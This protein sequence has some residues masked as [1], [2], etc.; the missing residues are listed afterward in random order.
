LAI[1]KHKFSNLN[2]C[3]IEAQQFISALNRQFWLGA[4]M[5]CF[6]S[7]ILI[8]MNYL[9]IGLI[10]V[11]IIVGVVWSM[12]SIMTSSV[13]IH[14]KL[15]ALKEK[16]KMAKTKEELQTVWEELKDVN[17]ECWHRSFSSKVV[18]VKTIIETKYD[19]LS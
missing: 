17:K 19:M 16:A 15:N 3:V 9:I 1:T 4:V 5:C 14:E 7:Q 18:E 8:N 10:I 11:L 6:S 12:W 2:K 13:N